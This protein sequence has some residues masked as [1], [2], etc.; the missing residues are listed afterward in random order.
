MSS[1]IC[2]K[3]KVTVAMVTYNSSQYLRQAIESVLASDY[4]HYELLIGDDN[5]S[6]NTWD[7]INSYQHPKIRKYRNEFNIGEY[8]NR[9]KCLAQAAGEYIIFIDGDD[10]IYPWG[11][12]Y[13]VRSLQGNEPVGMVLGHGWMETVV[14]PCVVT[15]R[16]FYRSI[17]LGKNSLNALNFTKILFNTQALREVGG[18][19]NQY[20][21]GDTHAQ[22][23]L[24]KK[25]EVLLVN[26]GFSWWRRRP[27]QASERILQD[28]TAAAETF[29]YHKIFLLDGDCPLSDEEKAQ[30]LRNLWGNFSRFL[31]RSL[32]KG[33]VKRVQHLIAISHFPAK[34]WKYLFTPAKRDFQFKNVE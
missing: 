15:P 7:I 4:Q 24:A 32:F 8:P 5:S 1:S 16:D 23:L 22:G 9:N 25:H 33:R 29:H 18:L 19:N 6:D 14:F 17:F 20:R 12:D 21:T 26:E 27:N 10:F 30:A 28:G 3:L 2:A 31:C 34:G 13:L 11:L